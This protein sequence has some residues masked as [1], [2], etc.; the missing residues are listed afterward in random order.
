MSQELLT[1]LSEI[2]REELVPS[3]TKQLHDG[4]Y[5]FDFFN[6]S[7][8]GVD[9]EEIKI[10]YRV[11]RNRGGGARK[12]DDTLPEA[13]K[14]A[15]AQ[16]TEGI[17][18][19]YYPVELSNVAI[20]GAKTPAAMINVASDAMEDTAIAAKHDLNRM[21]TK[22]GSG[23]MG[24][25]ASAAHTGTTITITINVTYTGTSI[26]H[27]AR[28]KV[29]TI[30]DSAAETTIHAEER[31]ITS[32]QVM[33][34]T[35]KFTGTSDEASAMAAGDFIYTHGAYDSSYDLELIGIGAH[36]S[37]SNPAAGTYQGLDRT[38]AG[39][40]HLLPYVNT[41]GS[42]RHL[43][44][45]LLTATIKNANKNNGGNLGADVFMTTPGVRN[46]YTLLLEANKQTYNPVVS[47]SGFDSKVKFV[48][49]GKNYTMATSEDMPPMTLFLI[50]KSSFSVRYT[51]KLGWDDMVEKG[52][53]A[54][55]KGKDVRWQ[56]FVG[57]F[58]LCCTDP[59][60]NAKLDNI[61]EDAI[62]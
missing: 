54:Y 55:E 42:A 2:L 20:A 12:I 27:F 60:A 11:Q 40:E 21:F 6:Y 25:V 30:R 44:E 62:S 61:T 35:F 50:N 52:G 18:K 49:D 36:I 13:G 58:N 43:T 46:A 16:G 33:D 57:Y 41:N 47:D 4:S 10:V 38:A 39:N 59:K 22:D 5:L 24:L 9:Q 51:R 15:W 28:G 19:F 32:V 8:K 26:L 48:Y 45:A 3:A 31:E 56:R 29:I 34:N 37:S 17:R 14:R 53:W 1:D 23:R 7:N